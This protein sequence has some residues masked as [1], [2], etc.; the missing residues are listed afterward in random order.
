MNIGV[1]DGILDKKHVDIIGRSPL[2][3]YLWCLRHQTK[4]NGLVLGGA[5]VTYKRINERLGQSTRTLERWMK[6][7]RDSGYI[8]VTHLSYKMMKIRVLKAKKFAFKQYPLP[9]EQ[10]AKSGGIE[11]R[12]S[13]K[14]GGLVPP[15]VA[16]IGDKSGGFKQSVIMR[17]IESTTTPTMPEGIASLVPI[18]LWLQF[19]QMRKQIRKPL[20]PGAVDLLARRLLQFQAEGQDPIA[21]LEQSVMN[22]WA[23]IFPLKGSG[24]E[25]RESFSERQQR[26]SKEALDRVDARLDAMD[27]QMGRRL[28]YTSSK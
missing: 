9:M 28:P 25:K 10:S 1:H 6:I 11:S 26:Q 12:V 20:T 3:L 21:V 19:V 5:P 22:S 24:N 13:A 7:L 2:S 16:D 4:P 18:T 8:E 15:K 17:E 23:G 27:A 14:S